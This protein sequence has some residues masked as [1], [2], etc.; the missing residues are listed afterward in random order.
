M[1]L[2][3]QILAYIKENK[4]VITAKYSLTTIAL[5]GSISTGDYTDDSDID[6]LVE[7]K[8]NTPNLRQTKKNI[9][10]EFKSVFNRDVDVCSKK[11]IK[12]YFRD[13]ILNQA[14]YV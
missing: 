9:R 5:F 3:D 7:F 12:P 10:E 2:K 6:L 1:D 11:Y 8:P 13:I 14:I 4:D